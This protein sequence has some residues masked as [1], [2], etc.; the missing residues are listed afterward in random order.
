MFLILFFLWV[1]FN[2]RV[3]VEIVIFG[4]C[5][6]AAVELFMYKYMDY[7]PK[8][9]TRLA[10]NLLRILHYGAILVQEVVKANLQVISLIFS[11]K[12][13]VEPQIIHFK[14]DLKSDVAKVTLANSITLTPGTITISLEE[15]TFTVLC[16]DKEF[17]EG[18]EDSQFVHLL[19]KM[20]E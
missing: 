14:S 5:I 6:A 16:L 12:Y 13:E 2:G 1:I 11:T 10:K 15:D 7:S 20:E 19:E 4:A 17:A 18:I 8:V 9:T 3:T